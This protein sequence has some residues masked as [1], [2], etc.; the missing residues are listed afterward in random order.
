M[1]TRR[2]L[3]WWLIVSVQILILGIAVYFD[4]HLFFWYK[5]TTYISS[6]IAVLYYITS[7]FIGIET[8]LQNK[9]KEVY[10]FISDNMMTLGLIGTVIG[11]MIM[12]GPAFVNIDPAQID[13]VK[14]AITLM[15]SGMSTALLTT[16]AGL[17]AGLFLKIQLLVQDYEK[18]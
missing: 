5:D 6:L 3:V 1:I 14:T 15:A 13:T 12:V 16:L 2:F 11:F 9:S 4:M 10:W 8:A 17:I 18:E 7:A